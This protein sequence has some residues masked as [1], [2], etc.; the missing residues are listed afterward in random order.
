MRA[1][2][3]LVSVFGLSCATAPAPRISFEEAAREGR[4]TKPAPSLSLS[5]SLERF[6]V[7]S[8]VRR[9]AMPPGGRMPNEQAQA[10]T[11]VLDDAEG[12]LEAKRTSEWV[13]T[14]MQA[15]MRLEA[16][17]QADAQTF[18]DVPGPLAERVT[19]T[20]RR[21]SGLIARAAPKE[22][23]VDPRRFLWPVDPVVVSS[24]YGE[25]T[26]PIAGG[27]RFHA[28]ID[29]EAP[30]SQPVFA[31]EAGVV[32]FASWNGAHGNQIEVRHDAHWTTRYSHLDGALVKEGV[33]VK[34]GQA[35]GL[36]GETGLAT[37]PHLHFEL[38]R[39]GD[40]LDPEAFLR[41]PRAPS[42]LVSRGAP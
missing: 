41:I 35:I 13:K 16:E 26:H 42:P 18:G 19:Q 14:A 29:L 4:S 27:A 23:L 33:V 32:V 39:D 8:T 36:V 17:L 1:S 37:G 9:K 20:L 15:R 25:R 24:P 10:W 38:R 7:G 30:I 6:A 34:R 2:W 12:F 31:A 11:A 22:R 3:W 40:A 21:L 5:V 28:G